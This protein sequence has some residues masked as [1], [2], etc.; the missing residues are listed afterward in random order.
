MINPAATNA[1]YD[2]SMVIGE[3]TESEYSYNTKRK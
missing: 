1:L 2:S 3:D